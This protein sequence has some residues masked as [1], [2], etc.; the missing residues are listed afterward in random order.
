MMVD[1]YGQKANQCHQ[2]QHRKN[3]MFKVVSFQL[4]RLSSKTVFVGIFSSAEL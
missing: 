4:H 1:G 3:D 2:Q